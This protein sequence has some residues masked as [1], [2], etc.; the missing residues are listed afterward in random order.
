M[1]CLLNKIQLSEQKGAKSYPKRSKIKIR[2]SPTTESFTDP[3]C[4]LDNNYYQLH[5]EAIDHIDKYN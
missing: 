2:S 3:A 1:R 5:K 4:Y